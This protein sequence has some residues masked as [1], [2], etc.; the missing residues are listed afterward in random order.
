[1]QAEIVLI[2]PNKEVTQLV[3]KV[4]NEMDSSVFIIESS[5]K[6]AV[7]LVKDIISQDPDRIR[8]IACGGATLKLLRKELPSAHMVDIHPTEHEIVLALDQARMFGKE[9]GLLLPGSENLPVIEK[10]SGVLGLQVKVYEYNNWREL[11]IQVVNA[12]RNGCKVV[13]GVGEK[14]SAL[15]RKEGLQFISVSAGENTVRNALSWAKDIIEAE[16]REK[17]NVEQMNAISAYAHEG[18]IVVNEENIVSVFNPVASRLFGLSEAE[19]VGRPLQELSFCRCLVEIFE[20]LEKRLG[21]VHQVLNGTVLVNKIPIIDQQCPKGI[22]VTFMEIPKVQDETKNRKELFTKGQVARYY[23]DDIIHVN[24]KMSS[25]IAKARKYAN[26]D[27]TVLIRG[28]S[29]TGKELLAQSVHNEQYVRSK[30]PF[31]AVNCATLDDNLFKSELFGYTEG[32]FT[33]ASKGGKPGLFELANGGTLFLDEIGKM[34]LDQQG[35]LLRVLQEKEVRR[36]GSDRVIP[37]DV[38]VIA[39]SNENLE[40]LINKGPFREDLYF[41]LNVLNLVLPPLRERREDIPDQIGFFLQ[42]FSNKYSKSIFRLPP[43][44]IKKLSN[45]DWPGNSRQLEHF[46]ERCVVLADSE[47]DAS[48]IVLELL[49]EEFAEA[50][51]SVKS[52]GRPTEDQI[53]VG[54]ST[55]AEMNSEIVRRIRARAKLS[56]SELALKL[57]ISRPTLSKMLNYK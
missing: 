32:S 29:G 41:R 10:L 51:F 2:S 42:R 22:L 48:E 6:A 13:L 4:R 35:N 18:I 19:V 46:L 27:C 16:I 14:I 26:T 15:V 21:Y 17:V 12:R 30:G 57:G 25:V 24:S 45:M 37:V 9:I 50:V 43:L 36:I 34:K 7:T 5:F 54:I 55:L 20:G 56:N 47:R 53:S 52:K 8:V 23:F 28:E 40:D 39:A 31:I 11:E 33:G 3:E 44:V 1:M 38:R 49:E